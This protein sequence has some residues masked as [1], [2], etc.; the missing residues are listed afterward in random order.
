MK[1]R[2]SWDAANQIIRISIFGRGAVASLANAKRDFLSFLKD[3]PAPLNVLVD[4]GQ[5]EADPDLAASELELLKK[6]S[7]EYRQ[8]DS[9]RKKI[10]KIAVFGLGPIQGI[11]LKLMLRLG[12]FEEVR[13]FKNE[14]D[15][16]NWFKDVS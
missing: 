9:A 4:C 3:L 14:E 12:G 7:I 15:A 10:K 8:A 2:F 6:I 5:A 16:L 1:Y 11:K 13:I